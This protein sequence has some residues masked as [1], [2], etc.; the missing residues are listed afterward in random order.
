MSDKLISVM[1]SVYNR[2][3]YL[4]KCIDSI[5]AQKNVRTEI[6]IVDDGSSD[7]AEKICDEYAGKDSR[8]IVLH[9]E[10]GGVGSAR[11]RGL[12]HARGEFFVFVDSDDL[13]IVVILVRRES[14][15]CSHGKLAFVN[16]LDRS[17]GLF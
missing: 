6:I 14:G 2:E 9:Q 15:I 8:V 12:D 10:N 17:L 16:C 7:G 1:L 4:T 3:H 13:V 5:L 11:N